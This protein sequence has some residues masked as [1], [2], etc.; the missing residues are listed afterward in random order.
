MSKI[1]LLHIM[2]KVS[3]DG[4]K[5]HGPARQLAY[6]IPFYQEGKYEVCLLNLRKEDPACDVIRESGIAVTSLDRGKF[7]LGALG[8]IRKA[9][10][11]FEPD[12]LHLHGYAAHSFGRLAGK[13]HH[14]PVV[15]QEHFVDEK[16]PIYQ[17]VAD[18]FLRKAQVGGLA[19]S[20][21]VT[22]F[23]VDVRFMPREQIDVIG[24]GIPFEKISAQTDPATKRQEAGIP[25]DA[26]VIGNVGR[27]T[28]MKGQTYFLQAAA[29]VIQ[30]QPEVPYHVVLVGDG[31]LAESLRQEAQDL[32]IADRVT[33]PGYQE[34]VKSWIDLFDI[35]VVPS[36]F[37]EGFCS[38]GIEILGAGVP[39][40]IT[41]LPCFKGIYLADQNV[42]QIPTRDVPAL[43]AAFK[44]LQEDETYRT[45]LIEEGK[46][47]GRKYDMAN[48]VA[49]Y[50]TYYAQFL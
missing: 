33:F 7:D 17:R 11:E 22:D 18:W 8:D 24:N 13:L 34:D 39:L 16:C 29:Q 42:L 14:I 45:A 46:A 19:V 1:K 2:D 5:I 36:I 40:V 37:G 4:S 20:D 48:I 10:R 35:G 26:I 12:L 31:P 15:V 25:L 49:E 21:A 27:L 47:T 38:V 23:M 9:I 43:A 32:G 41:D 30:E 6:R 3:V 50:E 28:E 44:R